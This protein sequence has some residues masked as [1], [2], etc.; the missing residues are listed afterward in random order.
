MTLS[1]KFYPKNGLHLLVIHS[2][3]L[4][5]GNANMLKHDASGEDGDY[6]VGIGLY[7]MTRFVLISGRK[8]FIL[9]NMISIKL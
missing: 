6:I 9:S 2:K 4:W 8:L 5:P 3:Q 7:M 1:V